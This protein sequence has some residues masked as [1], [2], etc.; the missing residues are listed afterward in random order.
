MTAP[1]EAGER[2]SRLPAALAG[3][4]LAGLV[5]TGGLELAG[6]GSPG[7]GRSQQ[8]MAAAGLLGLMAAGALASF[9]RG[10][11]ASP[12]ARRMEAVA[13]NLVLLAGVAIQVWL[14]L[15]LMQSFRIES[16]AFY[17]R[18]MPLVLA[19]FVVHHLLPMPARMPFFALLCLASI[20]LVFGPAQGAWLTG[21]GLV[22]IG[23][24]RLPGGMRV[25][26]AAVV[27][28][29]IAVA[30]M[31]TGV[32]P[33]PAPAAIWPILGSM[34][35]FR[36]IIYLY[37]LKHAKVPPGAAATLAYFFMLPN[38]VF[39]LFPVVDFAM[40]RRTWYDRDAWHIYQEGVQ[41]IARGV[42]HLLVYRWVYQRLT[43][44]PAEVENLETLVRYA[45]ANFGLYLRVSGQFHLIVGLLHLFGF[46]LPPTHRFFYLASSFTEFWRRINIY[47]KDFTQKIFFQPAYFP[48]RRKL[49][50]TKALVLATLIV[51]LA[52][53]LLHSYQWFWLLGDWLWS[54][55]DTAFW[56]ILA[57]VLVG[58]VMWEARRGRARTIGSARPGW[59]ASAAVGLRAALTFAV[60]CSLWTLWTSPTFAAFGQMLGAAAVTARGVGVVLLVL[61]GIALAGAVSHRFGLGRGDETERGHPLRGTAVA[62]LPLLALAV[63]TLGP[64]QPYLP[65]AVRA[66]VRDLGLAELNRR[67]AE[68][69]QRG[70]YEQLVGVNRFNSQLWE[71]FSGKSEDWPW[72]AQTPVA[73]AVNDLRNHQLRP[74]F[75][76]M[77]HGKP[78]RTNQWGMRDREYAQAK[79]AGTTRI[80][81]LGSSVI[82]GDGVGDGEVFDE[83]LEDRLN[84]ERAAGGRRVEL[85]NFAVSEYS[86]YAQLTMLRTGRLAPFAPDLVFY[87]AQP[88]DVLPDHLARPVERR[89]P[90]G[91]EFLRERVTRAGLDTG[92]SREEG[93]RR[94][95]PL[96]P[97][98]V[99]WTYRELAAEI[100]RIGARPVWLHIATPHAAAD[101]ATTAMLRGYA[102]AAGF[103]VIDMTNVFDGPPQDEII[104]APWDRHPNTRGHAML[105]ERLYRELMAR[106]ALMG[107]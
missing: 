27:A 89:L 45:L 55:T 26:V 105:A 34:F 17:G 72:L 73:E 44:S 4:A 65:V 68:L 67:D 12:L 100:R 29:G 11:L 18:L 59:A 94:I 58:N 74:L 63:A 86:P 64:V 84:R 102:R 57:L 31:R 95:R 8:A 36:T 50:D 38:V 20:A 28:L 101:S 25:R 46:R 80:A 52:T 103:E 15:L 42:T 21:I 60:L 69:L 83:V 7:L 47:W 9:G 30:L 96:V 33:S 16:E 93:N 76:L 70:Y 39:P 53:W 51:F 13:V 41:W 2:S 88:Y 49:G 90:I 56:G 48:L 1:S 91:L 85:L 43:I 104:V 75:G 99:E 71:V 77:Y 54:G 92:L 81:I 98:M 97:E 35:M 6:I 10:R 5:V 37:D 40:F 32:L 14:L 3:L 66:T 79:P 78:L 82:M 62:A 22:L 87:F 61:A 24:C 106:P 107:R 23:A 19:G